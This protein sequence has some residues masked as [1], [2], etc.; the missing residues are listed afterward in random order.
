[1][2]IKGIKRMKAWVTG[3]YFAVIGTPYTIYYAMRRALMARGKS[4]RLGS[5]RVVILD[6][7]KI[8]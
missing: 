3:K 5:V 7:D 8:L 6:K 2:E 4:W 1:M